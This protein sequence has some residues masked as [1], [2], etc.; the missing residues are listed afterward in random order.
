MAEGSGVTDK[1]AK[2]LAHLKGRAVIGAEPGS[3]DPLA[4]AVFAVLL[5][6]HG[7]NR[8]EASEQISAL[9]DGD[10]GGLEEYHDGEPWSE[11]ED[12]AKGKRAN[13]ASLRVWLK[14]VL[15]ASGA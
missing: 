2:F 6:P 8:K 13:P 11:A 7:G 15:E 5:P 12:R 4:K 14:A 1:Q 9:L 10:E 3:R